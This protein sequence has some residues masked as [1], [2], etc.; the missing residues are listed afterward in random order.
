MTEFHW[1]SHCNSKNNSRSPARM[2]ERKAKAEEDSPFDF[3]Q[4]RICGNDRKKRRTAAKRFV[5]Y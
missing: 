2:T 5:R 4:G 3:A 1:I